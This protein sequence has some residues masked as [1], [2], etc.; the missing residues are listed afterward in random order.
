MTTKKILV[1]SDTCFKK[2]RATYKCENTNIQ[3]LFGNSH[4]LRLSNTHKSSRAHEDRLLPLKNK[5]QKIRT[6]VL[7]NL[8]DNIKDQ[9]G[10]DTLYYEWSAL[11]LSGMSFTSLLKAC[12]NYRTVQFSINFTTTKFYKAIFVLLSSLLGAM[13][14]ISQ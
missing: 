11:D 3:E 8:S 1:E 13:N 6:D 7:Q 12:E 14:M 2:C 10:D 5:L 4:S 9:M